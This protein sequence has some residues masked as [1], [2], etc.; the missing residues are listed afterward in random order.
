MI[1]TKTQ[2]KQCIILEELGCTIQMVTYVHIRNIRNFN[3]MGGNSHPALL[4]LC[5]SSWSVYFVRLL[6]QQNQF[7][8]LGGDIRN[9]FFKKKKKKKNF[10]RRNISSSSFC[11][12]VVLF[13]ELLFSIRCNITWTLLQYLGNLA[14]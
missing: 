10:L 9:C 4:L 12:I 3:P 2:G 7:R 6:Q 14:F 1:S 11:G 5:L 8:C 13:L